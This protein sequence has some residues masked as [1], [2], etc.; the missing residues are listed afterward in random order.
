MF[1]VYLMS[2]YKCVHSCLRYVK[3]GDTQR[4]LTQHKDAQDQD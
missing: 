3:R 1:I 2:V 4:Y